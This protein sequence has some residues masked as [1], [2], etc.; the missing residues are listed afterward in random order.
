MNKDLDTISIGNNTLEYIWVDC[1][2]KK[3]EEVFLSPMVHSLH[4]SGAVY[5]GERSYKGKVFKL[6]EHSKRLVYSA[7]SLGLD[8]EYSASDIE[9]ITKEFLKINKA[10][11]A[12][13][14]P[15][16]F[17]GDESIKIHH[18][19]LSTR[20]FIMGISSAPSFKNG[21]KINISKWRKHHPLSLDPE[22]K[23]S[24]HYATAI[25]SQKEAKQ[26]GFDDSIY[27]DLSGNIAECTVSNI[28]FV[29]GKHIVTPSPGFFLN[30]ITRQFFIN[31]ARDMGFIVEE[32][33]LSLDDID[34]FDSCFITGTAVEITGVSQVHID[35][36]ASNNKII[37]YDN[38][39]LEQFQQ[40]FAKATGKINAI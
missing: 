27:L 17:R 30:G 29:N 3:Y 8:F 23:S 7:A 2:F 10:E 40:E 26:K 11:D 6:E 5:E 36:S 9:D 28:F 21:L 12:Y 14:R 24:A 16:V 32:T 37:N 35:N 1:E 33:T 18:N 31:M 25:V 38:P 19:S 13:I 4:Y 22:A 15:I 39:A 34:K 20:F